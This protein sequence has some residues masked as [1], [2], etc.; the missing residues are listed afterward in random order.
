[1]IKNKLKCPKNKCKF[2]DSTCNV[3][4]LRDERDWN[5]SHISNICIR[6]EGDVIKD[7]YRKNKKESTKCRQ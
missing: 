6:N 5:S 1:M 2:Y 7:F 3:C 4:Y